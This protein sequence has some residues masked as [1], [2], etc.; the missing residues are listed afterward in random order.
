LGLGAEVAISVGDSENTTFKRVSGLFLSGS[1]VTW[2][3]GDASLVEAWGKDVVPFL[4][5]EWM[6]S[7]I[8]NGKISIPILA[9]I[10]SVDKRNPSAMG[11]FD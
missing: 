8:D 2:G 10:T 6:G 11:A 7:V 3:N 4:S 5:H 9:T 1:L